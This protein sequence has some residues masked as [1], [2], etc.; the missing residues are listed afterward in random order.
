MIPFHFILGD[1]LPALTNQDLLN[2]HHHFSLYNEHRSR[3]SLELEDCMNT[4][5]KSVTIIIIMLCS[6]LACISIEKIPDFILNGFRLADPTE[7][8]N[9]ALPTKIE[10]SATVDL[11]EILEQQAATSFQGTM[12]AIETEQV[13]TLTQSALE[14]S[15]AEALI[16][17]VRPE[18]IVCEGEYTTTTTNLDDTDQ[19]CSFIVPFTLEFWNVGALGGA[20]YVGATLYW[21]YVDFQWGDCSVTKMTETTSIGEFSG[22]PDGNANVAWA[23]IQLN[24]GETGSL[25]YEDEDELAEGTCT[26][27]N[28][29]VF[30]GWTEP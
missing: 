11:Y 25:S 4:P 18:K 3:I 23:S 16:Y 12:R 26:I 5:R 19:T 22:G 8:P 15:E 2:N 27:D 24:T 29:A 14:T 28:P 7:T 17:G 20:D 21:S 10:P 6:S 13:I 30:S 9:P 1:S